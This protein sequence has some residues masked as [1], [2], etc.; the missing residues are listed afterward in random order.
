MAKSKQQDV[1]SVIESRLLA[2]DGEL[3]D[4]K[5]GSEDYSRSIKD[6]SLL[7]RAIADL[8]KEEIQDEDNKAKREEQ[9]RMNDMELEFKQTQITIDYERMQNEK[10]YKSQQ[11]KQ[12]LF[13]IG[14]ESLLSAIG[15]GAYISF[16]GRAMNH[17]YQ[18]SDGA[19]LI[20]PNG[21][22]RLIDEGKPKKKF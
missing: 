3:D 22:K 7:A 10:A 20:P 11:L 21:M 2:I 5:T 16:T 6:I 9:K 14:V 18:M 17:E 1:K 19:N 4:K 15:H 8:K 12:D 13:K